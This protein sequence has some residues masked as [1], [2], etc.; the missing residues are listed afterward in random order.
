MY[1]KMVQEEQQL[2]EER[3]ERLNAKVQMYKTTINELE[4]QIE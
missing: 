4:Q 3:E 2:S 1:M